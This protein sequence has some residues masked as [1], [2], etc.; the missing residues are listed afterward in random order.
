M[1]TLFAARDVIWMKHLSELFSLHGQVNAGSQ[2]FFRVSFVVLTG[3][4]NCPF[5]RLS[6]IFLP[7]GEEP[8]TMQKLKVR[9]LHLT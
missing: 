4:L 1:A 8:R 3:I 5:L 2:L 6:I 7:V 9:E